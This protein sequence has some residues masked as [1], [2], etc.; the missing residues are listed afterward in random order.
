MEC[1][2][3]RDSVEDLQAL[4]LAYFMISTD[5]ITDNTE[6]AQENGANFPILSD[7][8][9]ATADAYGVLNRGFARRVTFYIA[10]DGSIAH[11]DKSV[12]VRTAGVD[13]VRRLTSL[14]Y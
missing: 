11:I 12:S 14:G 4:D 8:G 3:L 5:T 13:I 7:R 6:F 9:G 1:K 2:S 10:P